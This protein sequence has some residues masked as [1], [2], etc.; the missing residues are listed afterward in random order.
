M[1]KFSAE[2]KEKISIEYLSGKG[3]TYYLGKKYSVNARTVCACK[4]IPV[5]FLYI[6]YPR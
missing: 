3:S 5:L 1:P 2:V 6:G 4:K